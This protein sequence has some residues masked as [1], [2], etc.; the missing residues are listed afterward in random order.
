MDDT[1]PL[2]STFPS[3]KF[4]F[5]QRL[6]LQFIPKNRSSAGDKE[7]DDNVDVGDVLDPGRAE[8]AVNRHPSPPRFSFSPAKSVSQEL[9]DIDQ[10][11]EAIK[12]KDLAQEKQHQVILD[13]M[14]DLY[15]CSIPEISGAVPTVSGAAY[16]P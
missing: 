2:I 1:T 8:G 12:R 4:D 13:T 3:A 7:E 16:L 5:G 15:C 14:E 9:A 6:T 11:L 10:G